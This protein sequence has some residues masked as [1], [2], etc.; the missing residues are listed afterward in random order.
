MR[1][2][3]R[4]KR[5]GRWLWT[6]HRQLF[7]ELLE[8]GAI[9]VPFDVFAAPAAAAA[10]LERY[11]ND[12]PT[13]LTTLG[14]KKAGALQMHRVFTWWLLEAVRSK[15]AGSAEGRR[16]A[17]SLVPLD[18]DLRRKF[19]DG[20]SPDV[21]LCHARLM[22]IGT[23]SIVPLQLGEFILSEGGSSGYWRIYAAYALEQVMKPPSGVVG[24]AAS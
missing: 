8:A 22:S 18:P 5:F 15:Q 12:W 4:R 10:A 24:D 17:D 21:D 2:F 1:D 11:A 20:G 9:D 14:V 3:V 19:L 7:T 13:D 23:S 6:G 16:F